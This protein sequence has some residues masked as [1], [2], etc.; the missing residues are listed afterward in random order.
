MAQSEE[1]KKKL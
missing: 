1:E